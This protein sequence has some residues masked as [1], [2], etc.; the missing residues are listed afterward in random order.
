MAVTTWLVDKSALVRIPA[1]PDSSLWSDRIDRGLVR[2]TSLTRLEIG[3]SAHSGADLRGAAMRPPSALMALES[4]T[5]AVESRAL[6]VQ[7]R[8]TDIGL[9]RAPSIPHLV[10]AATAELARLTVL[11]LDKGFD[12]IA[13]VTAQPTD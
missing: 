3:F 1:S 13:S 7:Q 11:H 9:H 8:L 6:D 5:P 2:I 10:I 4:L 12:L